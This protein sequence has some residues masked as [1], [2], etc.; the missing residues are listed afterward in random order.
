MSAPL[1][2]IC[3]PTGSGKSHL[4]IALARR[5]AGE[6]INC[7]SLQV[8][9][10]F[11]I[12]TAKV[13]I[14]E[15]CGIEHHLIDVTEA[16]KGFT[17]AE[18]SRQGRSLLPQITGRSRLPIVAGGTGFYLR[19]L[20]DGLSPAPASDEDL[21]LR[22]AAREALKPGTLHRILRR[23]HPAAAAR[24]HAN[25]VS[26]L[27]RALEIRLLAGLQATAPTP[28]DALRGYRVL[29]IGLFPPRDE[30]YTRLD[31]RCEIMLRGGLLN[32]IA[33]MLASGIP[34]GAKPLQSLGYKE[35]L[36]ILEDRLSRED[37]L[38]QMKRDT[39]RYA[40]RQITWFRHEPGIVPL[41]GFGDDPLIVDQARHLTAGLLNL[42]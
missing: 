14:S 16:D 32:E 40:K 11:D 2:A 17:A 19:A 6:I 29:K 18:F 31:Q 20:L 28:R 41:A 9:R 35:G 39:R 36:A 26:K 10:Q 25:D 23:L 27:I 13:P 22:L 1:L 15:R 12:G 8:Y 37:A 7:D 21:R 5:F 24:I 4:A 30:L 3:G 38:I 33:G 42:T 34:R